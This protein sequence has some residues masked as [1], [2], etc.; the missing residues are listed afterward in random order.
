MVIYFT[1]NQWSNFLLI[2]Q[3][4]TGQIIMLSFLWHL[5]QS[6]NALRLKLLVNVFDVDIDFKDSFK[7]VSVRSFLNYLPL[8]TGNIYNAYYLKAKNQLPYSKYA[9]FFVAELLV[10]LGVSGLVSLLIIF[11]NYFVTGDF[12]IELSVCSIILLVILAVA[13]IANKININLRGGRIIK[14]VNNFKDGIAEISN[15]RELIIKISFL[16]LFILITLSMR[17]FLVSEFLNFNIK[18]SDIFILTIFTTLIRFS[19]IIPGNIGIRETIA[20]ATTRI[21]GFSFSIGFTISLVDR[22]IAI[23]WIFL[24]GIIFTVKQSR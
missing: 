9:S 17:F 5:M 16:F 20:G 6:I 18:F 7:L 22:V 2:K 3:M 21:L 24:Y 8:S 12:Y 10:M 19:S 4:S 15:N 14:F 23:F 1:R 13:L 11:Y